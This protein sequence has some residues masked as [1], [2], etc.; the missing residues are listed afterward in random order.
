MAVKKT[1][2]KAVPTIN[3][4]TQFVNSW[5][6]AVEY[7]TESGD[8]ANQ[9]THTVDIEA[10]KKVNQFTKSELISMMPNVIESSLFQTHYDVFLNPPEKE[11]EKITQFD[12]SALRN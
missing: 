12:I 9:Y 5:E 10:S 7:E 6:L 4:D 2:V 8:F 1:L 3:K 11:E